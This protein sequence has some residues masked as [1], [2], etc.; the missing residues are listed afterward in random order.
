MKFHLGAAH[1]ITM[2]IEN[3]DGRL[4]DNALNALEKD[5]TPVW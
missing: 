4:S 5:L 1:V 2:I 3:A